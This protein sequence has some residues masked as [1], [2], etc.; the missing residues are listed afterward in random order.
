ME[1]NG[2]ARRPSTT[3]VAV[4]EI[5]GSSLSG[6]HFLTS[7]GRLGTRSYSKAVLANSKDATL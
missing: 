2:H 7:N 6:D 1:Q 3:A 4:P 5:L